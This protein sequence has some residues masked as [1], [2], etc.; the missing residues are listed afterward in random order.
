MLKTRVIS[1]IIMLLLLFAAVIIDIRIF[2]LSIYLI[3]L[4]G[5]Y[6][7]FT[8]VG[9]RDLKL[10]KYMGIICGLLMVYLITN[11][12]MNHLIIPYISIVLLTLLSLPVFI[13]KYSFIDAGNTMIGILYIPIFFGYIYLIRAIPDTGIYLIW[14]V[15]IISWFSDTFAYFAGRAFGKRKLCPLVSP[16]KTFEG[17]L[18]GIIGSVAGSVIYG[19]ILNKISIINVPLIHLFALGVVGSIISQIGDLA[20]SA[21]KRNVGIKDYGRIMPGHGGILDRFDSILFVAP[22]IYYYIIYVL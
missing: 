16:K 6:E 1:A 7:Y 5:L 18:G 20:A 10:M 3:V 8:A 11:I 19:I 9:S 4:A 2:L 15:F 17:S 21:I 14:F 22:L 13:N 12:N